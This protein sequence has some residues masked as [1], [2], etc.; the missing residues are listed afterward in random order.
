M[1]CR[2]EN[3]H[4][5]IFKTLG[6]GYSLEECAS[7]CIKIGTGSRFD[8]CPKITFTRISRPDIPTLGALHY[9]DF[10]E[11]VT[12]GENCYIDSTD[13]TAFHTHRTKFTCVKLSDN[14]PGKI[15]IGNNVTIVGAAL[16][17]YGLIEIGDG[18]AVGS[19]T[20]IMDSSGHPMLGRNQ[21][22]EVNRI[23][24]SAVRIGRNVWIGIN[25]TI[26]KGITIGDNSVIGAN[27][28]LHGDVPEGC[29]VSGNPASIIRYL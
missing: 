11:C 13:D 24:H 14:P 12:V 4:M 6:D 15:I 1:A 28:V 21:D 19:M 10:Y 23:T 9:G 8:G 17:S 29:V 25:C 27:S 2:Y 26:L 18:S 22:D 20:T 3:I 7:P 5:P 16:V